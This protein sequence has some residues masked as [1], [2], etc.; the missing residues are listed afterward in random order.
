MGVKQPWKNRDED[1]R[2]NVDVV[3][4]GGSFSPPTPRS[5]VA[6]YAR[7]ADADT[8]ARQIEAAE[9]Y[10]RRQ[11]LKIERVY[12][13]NG[14]R[15][16]PLFSKL[17]KDTA[18]GAFAGVVVTSVDRL[19]RNT[20]ANLGSA[21]HLG[22]HAVRLFTCEEFALVRNLAERRKTDRSFQSPGSLMSR[23]GNKRPHSRTGRK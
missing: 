15:D 4:Q 3:L 11:G 22:R 14:E 9:Q 17:L 21:R 5:M 6:I 19:S 12:A 1:V 7:H 13:E 10:A 20:E 2:H 8:R 16:R 18:D 23:E